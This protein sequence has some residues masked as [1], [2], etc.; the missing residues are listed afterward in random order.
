MEQNGEY[1]WLKHSATVTINGQTRTLEIAVPLRPGATAE[2]VEALLSEADA[3]ME[4][5]SRHLDV[6]VA[7]LVTSLT[8]PP[9]AGPDVPAPPAAPPV[10]A[11]ARPATPLAPS[12]RAPAEQPPAP[13]QTRATPSLSAPVRPP[14][15]PVPSRPATPAPAPAPV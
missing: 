4:R 13:T 15:S 11:P 14:R 10:E 6:R 12:E 8:V 3:C 9:A 5:L 2:E 1:L 7:A